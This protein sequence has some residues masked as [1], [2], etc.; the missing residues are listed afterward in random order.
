MDGK[1][2]VLQSEELCLYWD[3]QAVMS[4]SVWKLR[5][6][7]KCTVGRNTKISL[8]RDRQE[9][10]FRGTYPN[11]PDFCGKHLLERIAV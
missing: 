1:M 6:M 10:G 2:S 11:S 5:L 7:G 3:I 9:D 4:L 8:T